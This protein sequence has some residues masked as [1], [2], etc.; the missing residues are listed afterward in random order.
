MFVVLCDGLVAQQAPQYTQY[1]YNTQIINAGYM[2][3]KEV[4]HIALLGRTQWTHFDGA[5]KT[6]TLSVMT[7]LGLDQKNAVGLSVLQ[8]EIGPT[9]TS[10]LAFD[11]AYSLW[12][13]RKAK[14]SFGLKAGIKMLNVDF[15]KLNIADPGDIFENN[16]DNKIL[17]QIGA[18]VYYHNDK[19]Y[20][21]L[22][23]PTFFQSEH[24]NL[25]DES[26]NGSSLYELNVYDRLHYYLIAGHILE[27]SDTVKFKPAA[28]TKIV[29]GSPLQWDISANFL[30]YERFVVGASYRW[31]SAYS[32]MT[33]FQISDQ[34]FLGF[35]YDYQATSIEDFSQG[36]Y[37]VFLNFNLFNKANCECSIKPRFF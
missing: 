10:N 24:F 16:V 8:D 27:I 3:T 33:G 31:S 34:L 25:V 6:G 26:N 7:P 9:V 20:I 23:V 29:S 17:P 14:I 4:P 28:L 15:S 30:F 5:P 12:V 35:G 37:E 21:G 2:A 22:S 32:A 13:S 19:F 36:S 11:Y 1:M 18:G